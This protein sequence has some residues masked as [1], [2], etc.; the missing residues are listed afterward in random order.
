MA[1][2]NIIHL[3]PGDNETMYVL[4]QSESNST[5][6]NHTTRDSDMAKIEI[7]VQSVVLFLAIF[8]NLCVLFAL[9][10]GKKVRSRMHMFIMHLSIADLLVA[11]FNVLPQLMW[12]ISFRFEG[13]DFLCRFVKYMQL[14]VMYLTSYVL[15]M[16][17]IDRYLAICHPLSTHTWTTR[18]VNVMVLGA[19]LISGIL[20]IPQAVLFKY[21]RVRADS[22]VYDCWVHFDPPWILQLYITMFTFAVYI[23]PFFILLFTYGSICYTIWRKHRFT[24]NNVTKREENGVKCKLVYEV[25]NY[26][27]C[28]TATHTNEKDTA[29]RYRRHNGTPH[30]RTHSVRGFSRAKLKTIKLTFVVIAAYLVCWSPFFISQLWWLFDETATSQCLTHLATV[31]PTFF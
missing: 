25:Q 20:S 13:G 9:A 7:A 1:E 2:I 3:S 23:I 5:N 31:A 14:F 21:Q 30:P 15:V 19:Y 16:T 26:S 8:G 6:N 22:D 28:N 4:T 10:R 24:Q 17:A 18:T 12:D 11:F 29:R 27:S